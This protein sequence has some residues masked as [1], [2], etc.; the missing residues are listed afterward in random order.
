MKTSPQSPCSPHNPSKATQIVPSDCPSKVNLGQNSDDRYFL[1]G[2]GMIAK[3]QPDISIENRSCP[4]L[5]LYDS[6][7]P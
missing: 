6:H 2:R 1:D 3:L 4:Q 5:P 7:S